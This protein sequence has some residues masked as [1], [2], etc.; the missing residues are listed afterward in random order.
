MPWRREIFIWDLK[1]WQRWLWRVLSF[2]TSCCLYWR[3][4]GK[5]WDHLRGWI[6]SQA[7]TL[8][9]HHTTQHRISDEYLPLPKTEHLNSRRRVS[10][11]V[12]KLTELSPLPGCVLCVDAVNGRESLKYRNSWAHYSIALPL[13][14][15]VTLITPAPSCLLLISSR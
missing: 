3:F 15:Y 13:T 10:S 9:F 6:L 11:L 14:R 8:H 2:G 1:F 4:G 5:Y 12:T 7:S